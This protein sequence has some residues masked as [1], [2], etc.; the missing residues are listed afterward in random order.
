VTGTEP[1]LCIIASEG[2]RLRGLLGL[3]QRMMGQ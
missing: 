3:A 1:C 2:M